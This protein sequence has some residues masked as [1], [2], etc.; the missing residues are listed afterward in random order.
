MHRVLDLTDE[1]GQVAGLMLRML[2]ADVVLVEPPGGSPVRAMGPFSGDPG[3]TDPS[4][5]FWGWNRG[6]RSVSLDLESEGGQEHLRSLVERCDV[7]IESGAVPLDLPRLRKENPHLVTVSISAFGSSGPKAH[8]P[9]T[10]LTILAAGGQL[11]LT[12]D[13]DRPPVRTSVPQAFLHAAGD[14]ACGALVALAE[15]RRSGLGQ[16]VDVSAQ[17]SVLMAT[18]SHVLSAPYR[19]PLMKR[20][21][22][23]HL[24]AG[25][26]VQLVWP[27]EDGF[28]VVLMLFGPAFGPY[29]ARLMG[30]LHERGLVSAEVA[31]DDWTSY[32]GRLF[33]RKVPVSHYEDLKRAVGEMCATTTKQQLLDAA[34][35]RR[36]LIGPVATTAD[37]LASTQLEA[38]DLWIDVADP[39]VSAHPIRVASRFVRLSAVEPLSDRA[40]RFGEHDAEVATSWQPHPAPTGTSDRADPLAGLRVIDLTWALSGPA[41]SRFLSDFGATVVHIESL[42]RVDSARTVQPFLD[43]DSGIENGAVYH[44]MNAGKLSISLN[45]GCTEGREVLDDLVAWADVLIESFSPRGRRSLGLDY[46]RLSTINP[47]LVMMSSCLFGQD[48]PLADYAGFGNMAAGLT[49]FFHLT[50]WPD[51][52]P[53]GPFSAYTD[54]V[55]PRFAVASL[56]SALEERADTGRGQYIDFAQ[57]EGAIQFLTPALLDTAVNDQAVSRT[58]NDDDAMCPHGVYAC[59]GDDRWVAIAC[60]NDREWQ[61]LAGL[62]GEDGL[63][64]LALDA[65]RS[66][67][68][69][70][71][72]LI[73]AWTSTRSAADVQDELVRRQ[74]PAHAV[75]HS[76]ECVADP[77]LQ[78]LRHFVEVPHP[79]HG[80]VTVEAA[81]V[82]LSATPSN[83]PHGAPILGLDTI[84]VLTTLL[85][86]DDDRVGELYGSGALD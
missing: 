20:M 5:A 58:G 9:A 36:L 60:R 48:G 30:W 64:G 55:S 53:A 28:A 83:V 41:T 40:P 67:R 78:H 68:R 66:R 7:L 8:W 59:A 61:Q 65:R 84:E 79:H 81:R 4:L 17:R 27:C 15:R 46:E 45:L 85:G 13:S 14:A 33:S 70:L 52:P 2:G 38:R 50:G 80:T 31:G 24:I 77:Q 23:G 62:M 26:D 63:A 73:T 43:D 37:L 29:T 39:A 35:E 1:R 25:I 74:V 16:H 21:A 12:G 51:R 19:A 11:V 22:G 49:G 75:Q 34:L 3:A 32:G 72:D 42:H 82:D 6:K 56:L 71:D 10:D 47:R 86:Y 54:Y 18:Q 44:N 57:A 69:E 76:P